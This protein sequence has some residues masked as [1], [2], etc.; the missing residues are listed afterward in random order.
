MVVRIRKQLF[1]MRRAA[2]C[3]RYGVDGRAELRKYLSRGE[4][5]A[6]QGPSIGRLVQCKPQVPPCPMAGIQAYV[7]MD[8]GPSVNRVPDFNVIGHASPRPPRKRGIL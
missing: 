7:A 8:R 5:S 1:Q 3:T 2:L 6:A 4:G